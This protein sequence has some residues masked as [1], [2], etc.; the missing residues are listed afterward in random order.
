MVCG[1]GRES[2]DE[3]VLAE[4]NNRKDRDV[5]FEPVSER[6]AIDRI[7]IRLRCAASHSQRIG[8]G[9]VGLLRAG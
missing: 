4:S 9:I 3:T 8:V 7:A 6:S 1:R 2:G 5:P